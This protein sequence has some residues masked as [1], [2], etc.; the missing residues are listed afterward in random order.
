MC[1]TCSLAHTEEETTRLNGCAGQ[2][3]TD[4]PIKALHAILGPGLAKAVK[5]SCVNGRLSTWLGLKSDF[6]SVERIFDDFSCNSSNLY[7]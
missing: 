5:R 3:C 6:D 2:R 1:K 7:N 4:S